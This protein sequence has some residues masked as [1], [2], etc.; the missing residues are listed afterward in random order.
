MSTAH[1]T[2][3]GSKS[4]R[5]ILSPMDN[6]KFPWHDFP[7]LGAETWIRGEYAA[8]DDP[9]FPPQVLP[10]AK[11]KCQVARGVVPFTKPPMWLTTTMDRFPSSLSAL[12]L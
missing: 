5:R 4:P 9:D 11:I 12:D 2:V 6:D 8:P 1:V 3:G 10:F 7:E